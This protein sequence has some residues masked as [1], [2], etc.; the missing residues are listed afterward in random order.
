MHSNVLYS[1]FDVE[2]EKEMKKE[3]SKRSFTR[4]ILGAT[5]K[6]YWAT[7]IIL[8]M[9]GMVLSFVPVGVMSLFIDDLDQG[10]SGS[11]CSLV[12]RVD[13][14]RY[15]IYAVVLLIAPLI[16]SLINSAVQMMLVN[17]AIS[18]RGM[19]C[20]AIY[21]KALRLTSTAKG[22]TS[23]GQLVNIMSTDTYVLLQFVMII[24]IIAMI[25]IM[26]SFP[27]LSHF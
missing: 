17:I 8:F 2:W 3:K 22:S 1:R 25:P 24:N 10:N 9:I 4:A 26:V 14:K 27:A 6:C 16:S 20:E 23:T 21:R 18:M 15:W 7:A 11:C 12:L 19:A 5:G 13:Q